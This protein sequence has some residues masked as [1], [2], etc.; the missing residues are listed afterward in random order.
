MGCH[1][2]LPD[3]RIEPESSASASEFLTTEP[4]Q[5]KIKS[6]FKKKGECLGLTVSILSQFGTTFHLLHDP[7]HAPP[8]SVS[9]FA[10]VISV[11]TPS[12]LSVFVVISLTF[13]ICFERRLKCYHLVLNSQLSFL[14]FTR[15]K[16]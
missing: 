14:K 1:F 13:Y 11:L 7:S 3:P 2:L 5:Y 15:V 9:H 4:P 16:H 6:I 10:S 12:L 8:F